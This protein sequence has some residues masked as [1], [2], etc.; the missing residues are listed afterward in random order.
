M[1][2]AGVTGA[3]PTGT[4]TFISAGVTLG[5]API[6]NGHADT[7][8]SFPDPG[9]YTVTASYVGDGNNQASSSSPLSITVAQIPSTTLLSVDTLTPG[10]NQVFHFVV[11]F[12]GYSPTG[13]VTFLLADGTSIGTTQAVGGQ[14]SFAY[15]FPIAGTYTVHASYAGDAANLPSISSPV[16]IT[17]MAQDFTLSSTGD[18]ATLIGGQEATG[19]LTISPTY[20]YSGT[21]N[22]SCSQLVAG[23]ACLFTPPTL[24]SLDGLSPVS[25]VFVI[26]TTASN[27][28]KLRK[29]LEP[30]DGIAFA[31]LFGMLFFRKRVRRPNGHLLHRSLLALLLTVSILQIVACSSSPSPAQTP[32]PNPGT[33]KG[34]HTLVITAADSAGGPS[35]TVS[36][37]LIV[38]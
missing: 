11:G 24:R 38:N 15:F 9:T 12:S 22:L 26:T 36:I 8:V 30:L 14:A 33:P 10:A 17:V 37:T 25:S 21:V 4:V 5:T 13:T 32:N 18:M 19:T 2:T 1:L 29:F 27:S 34:T 28:T 16:T 6:L 23:E 7:T 20:G 31:G 35:H 3:A